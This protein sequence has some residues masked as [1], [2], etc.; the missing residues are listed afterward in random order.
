[1]DSVFDEHR[2]C[3]AKW[4]V[5]VDVEMPEGV[6][7]RPVE[8]SD[9]PQVAQPDGSRIPEKVSRVLHREF[10][11]GSGQLPERLREAVEKPVE[12]PVGRIVAERLA[13]FPPPFLRV[14]VERD[15]P[16]G[17]PEL[18]GVLDVDGRRVEPDFFEELA[19]YAAWFKIDERG[20]ADVEGEA[21]LAII[22]GAPADM[23]V[24]L[25]NDRRKAVRL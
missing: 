15:R 20:R 4:D 7:H 25:Q 10:H 8:V 1:M 5:F 19:T 17:Q 21:I 18:V 9:Q 2:D 3:G 16:V 11:I 6:R 12:P 22:S 23:V 13:S 24:V 14:V